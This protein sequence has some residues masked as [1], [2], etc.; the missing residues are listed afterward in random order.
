MDLKTFLVSAHKRGIDKTYVFFKDESGVTKNICFQDGVF[1]T[2]N[3]DKTVRFLNP[4]VTMVTLKKIE[5][6][7]LKIMGSGQYVKKVNFDNYQIKKGEKRAWKL[8]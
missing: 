1:F 7:K 3:K 6:R 5:K 4:I 8:S 2:V